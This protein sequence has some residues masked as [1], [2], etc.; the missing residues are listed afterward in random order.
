[1]TMRPCGRRTWRELGDPGRQIGDMSE[2]LA[3]QRQPLHPNEQL[4]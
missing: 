4:S 3:Q 1:M 2:G